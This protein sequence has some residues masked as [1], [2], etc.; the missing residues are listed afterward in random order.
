MSLTTVDYR[1]LASRLDELLSSIEL[2]SEVIVTD[3]EIP[4]AKLVPLPQGGTRVPGLHPGSMIASDDF[5]APLGDEFW[6]GSP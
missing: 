1:E 5:D 2:G 4:R 3:G 6:M